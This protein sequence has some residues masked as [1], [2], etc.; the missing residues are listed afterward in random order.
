MIDTPS[1]PRP[2]ARPETAPPPLIAAVA[3]GIALVVVVPVRLLWEFVAAAGGLLHRWL[4]APVGRFLARWLLRPLGW[5]LHHLLWL[6]LTWLGRGL[7]W[8]IRVL[9]WVPLRALV[10]ALGWLGRT[11]LWRPLV[12]LAY[13]LLWLPA[14][15]LARLL[16]PVGRLV[17]A[18]LAVLGRWLW[19]G[20]VAV[21]AVLFDALGWAWRVAGRLLWW[22][23]LVTLRPVLLAGGWLWRHAIAP[24]GRAVAVAWR[25]T[26][27]PAAR[28][29]R[30][31][32]VRPTRQA[33][34]EVLIALG[35]RR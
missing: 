14:A 20:V 23:Y 25:A 22:C 34:R 19:R 28:W 24:V 32:V 13:H 27:T 7:A 6:P 18:G 31:A 3:R 10:R 29:L 12:W 21:A 1:P 26:V 15:W 35:L 33:S 2:P 9:I 17:A 16:A 11:L 8:L 5:L 4:L 30:D